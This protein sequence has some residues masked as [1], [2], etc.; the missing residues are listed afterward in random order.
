VAPWLRFDGRIGFSQWEHFGPVND[1]KLRVVNPDGTQELAIAGQHGKPVN[2]LFTVKEISPN[3]MLGIGTARDRT[4]HAGTLLT[5]D[6]RNH[7][8]PACLDG[9][10]YSSATT[11]THFCLDEEHA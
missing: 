11:G 1:V 4:I 6:A 5:I 8:D 10:A 3:V 9:S 2:A 7:N